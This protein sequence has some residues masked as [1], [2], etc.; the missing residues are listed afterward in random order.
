M[1]AVRRDG[2]INSN[3]KNEPAIGSN[4]LLFLF[5]KK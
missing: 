3:F 4:Y 2:E 1:I 5:K